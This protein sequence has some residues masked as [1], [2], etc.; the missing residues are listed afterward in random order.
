MTDPMNRHTLTRTDVEE[1][2]DVILT[3]INDQLGRTCHYAAQEALKII[4]EGAMSRW[5][6]YLEEWEEDA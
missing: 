4:L 5:R 1:E 3:N 2:L 6:E